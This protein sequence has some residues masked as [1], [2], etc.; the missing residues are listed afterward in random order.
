MN[1]YENLIPAIP[2][3]FE[4]LN[5]EVYPYFYDFC[6]NL[7]R[8][9]SKDKKLIEILYNDLERLKK[10]E[11]NSHTPGTLEN[12]YFYPD[13][14]HLNRVSHKRIYNYLKSNFL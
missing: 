5:I 11:T 3:A 10:F 1:N 7:K 2:S 12:F 4:F 6:R 13:G 8:F 14:Y 9:N